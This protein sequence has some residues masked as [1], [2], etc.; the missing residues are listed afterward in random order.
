MFSALTAAAFV[1]AAASKCRAGG[2]QGAHAQD[3]LQQQ[4]CV[5]RVRV[6]VS[7]RERVRVSR[8]HRTC[9]LLAALCAAHC[10]SG[11]A[12]RGCLLNCG[13]ACTSEYSRN[14]RASMAWRTLPTTQSLNAWRGIF[15]CGRAGASAN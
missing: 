13:I 4:V 1:L 8:A 2:K 5:A 12:C 15:R 9:A 10:A 7:G 3:R 14:A 6:H 11:V